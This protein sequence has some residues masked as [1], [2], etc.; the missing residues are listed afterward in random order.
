VYA[1]ETVD[2]S[3]EHDHV[4]GFY[5]RDEDLISAIMPF[6]AGA[7]DHDGVALVIATPAHRAAIDNALEED[8]FSI[9]TLIDGT[10]YRSLDAAD[11]LAGFMRD[12]RPGPDEFSSA[13]GPI[14]DECAGTRGPIRVFG[15]MVALLWDAGNIAAA[16]ELESQWNELAADHDFALYCAYAMS[17]L[18]GAGDLGAVKQVCDRHSSVMPLPGTIRKPDALASAADGNHVARLFIPTPNVLYDVRQFVRDVLRAW[19]EDRLLAETELITSELATN[20]V[21]HAR[22]PFRV[23]LSRTTSEMRIAVRDGSTARPRQRYADTAHGGGRGI[24]LVAALSQA[25]DTEIEVDG[26]TIWATM[27]R[28]SF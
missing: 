6:L 5:R 19:D 16:I 20:A 28:E 22:S 12:G 26:K 8:G 24:A 2:R 23:S 21:R 7:F 1:D 18:E 14:L 27:S 3:H 15:E 10:R 25:W 11:I 13:I 9:D 17:S 4:V